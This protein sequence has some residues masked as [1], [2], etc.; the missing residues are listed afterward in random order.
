M[1]RHNTA[2]SP[3]HLQALQAK[4]GERYR[5]LLLV[6]VMVGTMAAIMSSTVVNVAI[7]DLSKH[8]QL[9]HDQAQWVTSGFMAA[10]TVTMLTTPWMLTRF[11]FRKTYAICMVLLL[12]GSLVGGLS[13]LYPVVLGARVLEGL[14]AGVVQP[15]PAIIIMRAFAPSEQ[16]RASGLFGMGVV[17]APA[18]GPSVGGLLV[19]GY[20]WRSIFF[21][22]VPFCLAS[23]WLARRYVP[24]TAPGGVAANQGASL[25]WMGLGLASA[26]TSCLLLGLVQ[27]QSG[28]AFEALLLLC[29]AALVLICFVL[30][31]RKRY[32]QRTPGREPLMNLTLF[33][34]RQF[35]TGSLVAMIYGIALFGSTYLLPVYLQEGIGMSASYV[36]TLMLP[37]GLIL[38]VVIALGGKLADHYP[39]HRL[40]SLGLLLLALSFAAMALIERSTPLMWLVALTILGR[41]GLG[42]VLPSL[43]LGSLRGLPQTL[44]PQGASAINFVR[45]LGGA[46]GVSLCGVVL[47]WRL[48][49][50]HAAL[51]VTGTASTGDTM[52]AFHESFLML[53]G[54][55]VLAIVAALNLHNAAPPP[56]HHET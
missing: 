16:G 38:G 13:N 25:D 55:C 32:Q 30:W 21:M 14:A 19:D 43:N 44:M 28:T 2:P 49:A 48:A 33:A 34:H 26:G 4:H 45:M 36:G 15:I 51:H 27:L 1:S 39:A 35:A 3:N 47:Q 56:L 8:F 42:L 23:L 46:A 9:G 10:S 54:I 22:M 20:G 18:L 11:G 52:A 41:I 53:A 50:H 5:W 12:I 6:S 31:Q 29:L 37:A 40:I 7:P 17:L 24:D